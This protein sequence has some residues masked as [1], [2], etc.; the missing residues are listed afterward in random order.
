MDTDDNG[1]F[2]AGEGVDG[3]TVELYR[4]GQTP[5]E[6]L[7]LFTQVTS[8]GGRYVFNYLPSGYYFV[9]IPASEFG[10]D[11]PLLGAM[12][13]TGAQ[14]SGDDNTGEDGL[15]DSTPSVNGIHSDIIHVADNTAPTDATTETGAFRTDDNLDDNNFDLTI[16]FGFKAS[17]PNAVSIGNLVFADQNGNGVFDAGEGKNGVKV[18]LFQSGVN[19]LTGTPVATATTFGDGLYLFGNLQPGIYFVHIP[20]SEFATGKPLAGWQSIPGNGIDDHEDDNI[21]GDN[22]IDSAAPATTGIS[23]VDIELLADTEPTDFDVELGTGSYVDAGDDNNGDLTVDFGFFSPVGV[24]NLVFIDANKN[25]HADSGEGVSGVKV[26]LYPN[27]TTP[28]FDL[29]MASTTTSSNGRYTVHASATGVLFHSHS[30]DRVCQRKAALQ[31]LEHG[32][33]AVR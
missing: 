25:G 22:G 29:P 14:S 3:V 13:V 7:P 9:N 27:G 10:P 5:G 28:G 12:S 33:H 31:L 19:P 11:K 1:H 18:K 24:G 6:S 16:D 20:P 23:S 30:G 26:D 21:G 32:R 17:D 8:N 4:Q 15:D 2:D